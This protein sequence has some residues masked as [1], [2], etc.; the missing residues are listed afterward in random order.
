MNPS[1]FTDASSFSFA[2][3]SSSTYN[4][5]SPTFQ[6]GT[7]QYEESY[8]RHNEHYHG[9]LQ[10]AQP[11]QL[12]AP[13]HIAMPSQYQHQHGYQDTSPYDLVS[14]LLPPSSTGSDY[15][16]PY[17]EVDWTRLNAESPLYTQHFDHNTSSSIA[18]LNLQVEGFNMNPNALNGVQD[19]QG[20]EGAYGYS[21]A[22]FQ[23]Q[24]NEQERR[25]QEQLQALLSQYDY[26]PMGS[27]ST[28]M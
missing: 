1:S 24:L 20:T 17:G 19:S 9:Y 22:A 6:A 26:S 21:P 28:M 14:R 25:D 27:G 7:A 15:Q 16:S 23:S 18:D 4:S 10:Q 2:D 5:F 11:P 3:P 12:I 13:Y 8:A